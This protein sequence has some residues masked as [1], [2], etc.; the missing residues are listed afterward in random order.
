MYFSEPQTDLHL[1]TNCPNMNV[2]NLDWHVFGTDDDGLLA[3]CV[4]QLVLRV[5]TAIKFYEINRMF[6]SFIIWLRNRI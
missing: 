1:L 2:V 5:C 6:I 4:F 3:D